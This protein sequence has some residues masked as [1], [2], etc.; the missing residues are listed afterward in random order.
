MHRFTKAR[1]FVKVK[2]DKKTRAKACHEHF[3]SLRDVLDELKACEADLNEIRRKRHDELAQ[4]QQEIEELKRTNKK[5]EYRFWI[6]TII[7]VIGIIIA[8][9]V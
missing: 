9:F 3:I 1:D 2:G 6:A 4:K 7:G 5:Q 8:I